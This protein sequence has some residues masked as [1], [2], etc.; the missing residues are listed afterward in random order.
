MKILVSSRSEVALRRI[1]ARITA[2]GP[3]QSECVLM[4]NG[5]TDPL[6]SV[7]Y[8][9]DVLVLHAGNQ[10]VRELQALAMRTGR[11]RPPLI[12]VGE[13][14]PADAMRLAMRAGARDIIVDAD[15]DELAEALGRLDAERVGGE[16]ADSAQIIAVVNAK[17]GSGATF[18]ATSLA[19][20]SARTGGADTVLLD[21][22]FQYGSLPHYLDLV[23]QR[24]LL[25]ALA[26]A[27]E[28]DEVAVDAYVARHASGVHV[29]APLPDA[30]RAVD[31]DMA[32]RMEML[33]LVL[34]Q[35]Y[36]KII[37]DLPRHLDE[38]ASRVLHRANNV[39]M[40]LQ[41][42]LLSVH[43]AVRLKTILIREL[44]IP[45]DRIE[46][47]VN[48][49]TKNGTLALSDIRNAL[50]E[51]D[52]V[53]VPNHYTLVTQ[54]LDMGVSVVEQ[55][56]NSAVTRALIGLHGRIMGAPLP[57]SRGFLAKTVFRL[58]G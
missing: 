38:L 32:D 35:R 52:L 6:D 46:S 9:P 54:A 58:R 1:Q 31:F 17:G 24:G 15:S 22:D 56:P 5:H 41:P 40:V 8:C 49:Y 25:D 53:L 48:R 18:L 19:Q 36:R 51:E 50:D 20:L 13:N 11:Q 45:E 30:Q 57:E 33:L 4:V 34:K 26:N 39:L 16:D 55:A 28:I 7:D 43:D 3:H 21:L 14:L 44:G 27:Q 47:V 42:S 10:I 12:V 23:P 29:M 37:I 2:C